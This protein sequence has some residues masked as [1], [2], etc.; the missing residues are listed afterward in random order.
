MTVNRVR[1][2]VSSQRWWIVRVVALP[3]YMLAFAI[4]IFVAIRLL[5]GDPALQLTG[6]QVSAEQLAEVRHSLGLD[7]SLWHQL[8]TFLSSVVQLKLGTSLSTG[9]A[10]FSDVIDRL[11]QTLELSMM[12]LIGSALIA[13]VLGG[14]AAFAPRSIAARIGRGYARAAGALPDFCLGIAGILIFYVVLKVS[15]A[16]IGRLDP[17]SPQPKKVTG[18]PFFDTLLSGNTHLIEAASAR[19]LLP[20]LAMSIAYAPY[21]L[22]QLIPSLQAEL[23]AP[24]TRFRIASGASRRMIVTAV[25]R[26]ALPPVLVVFGGLVTGLLGG[27]VVIES[28]FSLGGLGQYL[29]SS[30]QGSDYPATQ[31]ALLIVVAVVLTTYLIVDMLTMLVDPRRRSGVAI[32]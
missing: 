5:P 25:F 32:A 20:V 30:V 9:R 1:T 12:A 11:P 28:M 6:G 15:P 17:R 13:A 21:L 4:L 16:P 18:F 2:V 19:L 8:M 10:V 23:S 7:G 26:R 27:A 14:A 22:K 3:L 29:V 31:G 24:A